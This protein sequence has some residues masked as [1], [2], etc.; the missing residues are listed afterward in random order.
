M[1]TALRLAASML[2][3]QASIGTVNDLADAEVDRVGKPAK[4]IPAGLVSRSGA[5]GWAG[6]TLAAGVALAAPSGIG[7]VAIAVLGV[8]L[9]YAYDV[10]LSRTS[11]AWLPLA[12]ALP[13][14]PVF[15]WLGATGHI[16][17][18]LGAL[19]PAAVAA[20]TGLIM[21]NGLVDIERDRLAGKAT[22][23]VRLGRDRAWSLH[24]LA[25]VAAIA[26]AYALAPV[27]PGPDG[28]G[29]RLTTLVGLASA[30]GLPGGAVVIAVGAALLTRVDAGVRERGWELEGIGTVVLGIGWLARIAATSAGGLGG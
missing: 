8:G 17:N 29:E 26:I 19:I 3:L 15:A 20:G 9:G 27:L 11:L 4:P 2:C 10:R 24:G 12:L 16:P 25:F 7:A 28:T 18:A 21:G 1:A 13:L 23:A 30:A 5:R 14:L 6:V 22:I